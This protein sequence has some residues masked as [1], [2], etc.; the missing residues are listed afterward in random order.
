MAAYKR[1]QQSRE[2]ITE[3]IDRGFHWCNWTDLATGKTQSRFVKCNKSVL[4]SVRFF[5]MFPEKLEKQ[6]KHLDKCREILT[7]VLNN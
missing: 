4:N 6:Q 3:Q 7:T 5:L 2:V 1:Q